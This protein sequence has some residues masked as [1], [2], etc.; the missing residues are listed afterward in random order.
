MRRYALTILFAMFISMLVLTGC[1]EVKEINLSLRVPLLIKMLKDGSSDTRLHAAIELGTYGYRSVDAVPVLIGTVRNDEEA[2]VRTAA[3][4][5]LRF[6]GPAA[7]GS[8]DTIITALKDPDAK[9][10]EEA[11]QAVEA[12]GPW[13]LD[14]F[15]D[16]LIAINDED[17]KVAKA[18]MWALKEMGPRSAEAVPLVLSRLT[19]ENSSIRITAVA[20]LGEIASAEVAIEPLI[21]ALGDEDELV[22]GLAAGSLGK[23][24][25]DAYPALPGLIETIYVSENKYVDFSIRTIG[26]IGP[27]AKE[28]AEP[29][30]LKVLD[31]AEETSLPFYYTVDAL[32]SIGTDKTALKNTALEFIA[33]DDTESINKGLNILK[34]LGTFAA[35]TVPELIRLLD[36]E[37]PWIV[38]G[39][40]RAIAEIGPQAADAIP[41]LIR[42]LE[43][44]PV[45]NVDIK[46]L[47][48]V[49][50][51]KFLVGERDEESKA[52]LTQMNLQLESAG[53]LL[54]L[55][56]DHSDI[57]P[58]LSVYLSFDLYRFRGGSIRALLKLGPD[59]AASVPALIDVLD[60][61]FTYHRKLICETLGAIGPGASKALPKLRDLAMNDPHFSSSSHTYDVQD[62]A[63]EAIKMI[64]AS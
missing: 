35:D 47:R 17:P 27:K 42:I 52:L 39:A 43:N 62:A 28:T 61:D 30:L 29:V 24:G 22:R 3:V 40:V 9:V 48:K 55:G 15:P 26:N 1:G 14:A 45:G 13:A 63:K 4:R 64:E 49:T 21:E 32:I 31:V 59:A 23:F 36:H 51:Y 10:R 19:D 44:G 37:D 60:A 11:V 58:V 7:D 56:Y 25:E 41:V 38:G 20:T 8:V 2:K 46:A 33:G 53:A 18:A 5:A 50:D 16:I 12:F 54:E 34:K 57:V 6:I